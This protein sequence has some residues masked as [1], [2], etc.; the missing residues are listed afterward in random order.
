MLGD[1]HEYPVTSF[2]HEKNALVGEQPKTLDKLGKPNKAKVKK[3]TPPTSI[4]VHHLGAEAPDP[5]YFGI[6]RYRWTRC[7]KIIHRVLQLRFGNQ[8]PCQFPR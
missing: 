3:K 7:D 2:P 8:A 6:H 4:I 5:I 1:S